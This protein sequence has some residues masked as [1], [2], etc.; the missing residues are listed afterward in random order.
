M[1]VKQY[2]IDRGIYC[3]RPITRG[4]FQ[5]DWDPNNKSQISLLGF[6]KSFLRDLGERSS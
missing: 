3:P 5:T 6:F 4:S 1:K 2:G